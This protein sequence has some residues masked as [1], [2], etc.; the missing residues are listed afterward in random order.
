MRMSEGVEWSVHCLSVLAFVPRDRALPAG[1][2]AE[3]HGVPTP[4]LTKHLQAL[5]RAGIV[6]SVSGPRGGFR[7]AKPVEQINLLE[8]VDA[9]DGPRPAFRCTEIRQR[10]P[11]ALE[12]Q[13]YRKPCGVAAAFGRADA[14]WR[15][16][17]QGTTLAQLVKDLPRTVHSRQLEKGAAWLTEV[18]K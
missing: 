12:P 8:V 13:C 5:A 7:L 17:L 15:A 18:M 3:L 14:A 6:V 10:G 16:A 9:I 11:T 1:R 4:Y 2:L